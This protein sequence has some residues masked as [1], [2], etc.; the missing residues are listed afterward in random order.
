MVQCCN[1]TDNTSPTL[2][3][4]QAIETNWNTFINNF[5]TEIDDEYPETDLT[6][7]DLEQGTKLLQ[8]VNTG[9]VKRHPTTDRPMYRVM[10]VD[11]KPVEIVDEELSVLRLKGH[12]QDIEDGVIHYN[13]QINLNSTRM[14]V[15]L[16][17]DSKSIADLKEDT[18]DP[19][20]DPPV[21][22]DPDLVTA[23]GLTTLLA[24]NKITL[25]TH[26]GHMQYGGY[27]REELIFGDLTP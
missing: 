21:A 16:S 15:A 18:G 12:L 6:K 25:R 22:A 20:A 1:Y 19:L 7:I 13:M 17:T 10:S 23:K 24:E 2:A 8:N 26:E 5:F 14:I 4:C 9:E 11:L 27:V 3:Q